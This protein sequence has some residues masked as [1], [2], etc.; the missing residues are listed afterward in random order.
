MD[1]IKKIEEEITGLEE[2]SKAKNDKRAKEIKEK[3]KLG[4]IREIEITNPQDIAKHIKFPRVFEIVNQLKEIRVTNPQKEVKILNPQK[5]VKVTG[6]KGLFSKLSTSL[7]TLPDK[8]ARALGKIVLKVDL[9]D[10]VEADEVKYKKHADQISKAIN[11][12]E[13][14]IDTAELAEAVANALDKEALAV[15][16]INKEPLRVLTLDPK[17][18]KP[19][20]PG[21]SSLAATQISGETGRITGVPPTS[22]VKVAITDTAVNLP[23]NECHNGVLITNGGSTNILL[24]GRDVT[25]TADGTGNGYVLAPGATISVAP[26]NANALWI[27]GTADTSWV[28]FLV[29]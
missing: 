27:N 19:V 1:S 10:V 9:S 22:Q 26:K 3:K 16:I 17:T 15:E 8:T 5:E 23:R 25:D 7:E 14:K 13:V 12:V 28:S 18:K 11:G 6:I 20:S 2:K 4:V 21:G 29:T 24:G